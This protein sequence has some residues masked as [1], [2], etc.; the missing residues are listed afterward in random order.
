MRTGS[1]VTLLSRGILVSS[2]SYGFDASCR[3]LWQKLVCLSLLHLFSIE[4]SSSICSAHRGL[5]SMTSWLTPGHLER[6]RG[7]K[8]PFRRR[9]W[10]R[11]S[12]TSP[13]LP[14]SNHPRRGLH[15]WIWPP[16]FSLLSA[17][18]VSASLSQDHPCP[19]LRS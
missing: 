12:T 17:L 1:H 5:F 16:C 13:L 11:F 19:R 15:R 9:Q 7:E 8:R 3:F 2:L 6:R 4:L 14:P 18:Q 10:V